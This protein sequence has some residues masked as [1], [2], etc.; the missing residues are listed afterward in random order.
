MQ[1]ANLSEL[2]GKHLSILI[3]YFKMRES[4]FI[5]KIKNNEVLFFKLF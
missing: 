3:K 5:K 1:Y 4:N 2:R